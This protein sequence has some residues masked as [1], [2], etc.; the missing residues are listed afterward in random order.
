MGRLVVGQLV[1]WVTFRMGYI[2]H[3]SIYVDPLRDSCKQFQ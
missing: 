2:G 1:E 3:G